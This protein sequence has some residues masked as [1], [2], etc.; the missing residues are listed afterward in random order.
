[1]QKYTG[2]HETDRLVSAVIT[3]VDRHLECVG[4]RDPNTGEVGRSRLLWVAM[5]THEM[6]ELRKALEPFRAPNPV[7]NEQRT[8]DCD[9]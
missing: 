9:K 4:L 7:R 2:D 8:K 3:V 6:K 1:M 5:R